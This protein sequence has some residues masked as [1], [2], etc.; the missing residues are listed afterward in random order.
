MEVNSGCRFHQFSQL[1]VSAH[2]IQ[3]PMRSFLAELGR[4]AQPKLLFEVRLVRFN[5]F[6][7]QVQFSGQPGGAKAAPN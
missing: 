3:R 2:R 7:A 6:H 1:H 5:R 4:A